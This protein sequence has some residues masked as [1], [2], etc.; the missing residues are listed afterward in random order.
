MQHA[1]QMQCSAYSVT[2]HMNAPFTLNKMFH[3]V[4]FYIRGQKPGFLCL[5]FLNG[6]TPVAGTLDFQVNMIF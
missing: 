4:E 3:H 6:T 1:M 2:E 5:G